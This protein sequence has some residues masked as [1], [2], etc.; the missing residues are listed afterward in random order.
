[1][2]VALDHR[3]AI[4]SKDRMDM[5]LNEQ[6]FWEALRQ[7]LTDATEDISRLR[8]V[9]TSSD[10]CA[11]FFLR[12]LMI[13][14]ENTTG[15]VFLG[16]SRLAAPLGTVGRSLFESVISTFWAS[17]S[18]DNAQHVIDSE[19]RELMRIM[20]NSLLWGRAQIV[21]N[22]TGNI[23]T[24][25]VLNHP[26]LKEA[27]RPKRFDDMA[28]EAGIKNIY[29]QLYGFLSM[30]AHGTATDIVAQSALERK[31][32]IYELMSL[33]R[34]CL[35]SIHLIVANRVPDGKK[36]PRTAL[37]KILNIKLSL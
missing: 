9:M 28:K 13:A 3:A 1:M 19:T 36:T 22:E 17:L 10:P 2:W 27:R 18:D 14:C 4:H 5:P 37:E 32:P 11:P 35:R 34:G 33:S 12:R 20:K 26:K 24:G 23:E 31:P 29:D 21:D 25:R 8:S 16:R 30:F 6:S 15:C 7:E